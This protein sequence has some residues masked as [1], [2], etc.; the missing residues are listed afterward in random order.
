MFNPVYH[1]CHLFTDSY[2]GLTCAEPKPLLT[3]RKSDTPILWR[4]CLLVVPAGL[5]P[6]TYSIGTLHD[7]GVYAHI[8]DTLLNFVQ[9]HNVPAS[10]V[11]IP[12]RVKLKSIIEYNQEGCY[13]IDPNTD[14]KLTITGWRGKTV[15][16][17]I[18]AATFFVLLSQLQM[19]FTS[20][21]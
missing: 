10:P 11:T 4:A 18:M 17:A 6:R 12:R 15:K 20:L 21:R 8:V 16:V 19:A 3:A 9:I 7:G 2:K 1:H 5:D 13:L 14:P